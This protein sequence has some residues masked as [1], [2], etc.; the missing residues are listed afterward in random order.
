MPLSTTVVSQSRPL[1]SVLEGVE[2]LVPLRYRR[3]DL[4]REN[5][6]RNLIQVTTWLLIWCF[7]SAIKS[8][9]LE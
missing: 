4:S 2:Y 7:F 9:N 6:R 3:A 1:M 8:A 5:E